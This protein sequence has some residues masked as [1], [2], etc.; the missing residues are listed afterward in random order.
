MI[1]YNL[2]AKKEMRAWQRKM[3][4]NPSV[5]NR[6]SSKLQRKMNGLIPEKVHLV[7]TKGIKQMTRAVFVGAEFVTSAPIPVLHLEETETVI[8]QKVKNYKKTAA[9]E[10]GITGAGGILLAF[11]DF[12]VLMGIKIKMLFDIASQYGHDVSDYK[13][14]LY[15]LYI[16]QL[17]FSS[18]QH[19]K[20]VF[21]QM[22]DWD[23][24]VGS[25]PEDIQQFDWRNFQQQYRD[26]MDLAKL[27]QMVPVVGAA[28]GLVVN[29]RLVNKLAVTAKNAYRMRLA[30]E[31]KL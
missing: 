10:G 4:R 27:A 18:H 19:R 22:M 29:Y 1:D 16:F 15:L 30:D 11:V 2:K 12:P 31:E 28:V 3:Q 24:K 8:A 6:V 20:Q 26:Y 17:A 9:A 25:L 5:L 23:K 21:G 14:R 13:E 7:I